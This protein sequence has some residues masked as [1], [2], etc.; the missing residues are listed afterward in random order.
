MAERGWKQ[1]VANRTWFQGKGKYPI[2]AYS[3]FMPPPRLGCK[4]Y[5]SAD[6]VVFSEEDPSGWHITEFEEAFELKPGLAQVAKQLVTAFHHLGRC[7]PSH[8]ISQYKLRDNPY[9]TERTIAPST[10]RFVN[11]SPLALSR[12]QDDK[13]RVRWTLFGA[14]EQGPAK[15]FW[16][17]FYTEPG[18]EWPSR[19]LAE[20]RAPAA[21]RGLWRKER[22]SG[23]FEDSRLSNPG[24][25]NQAAR[26]A[27]ESREAAH[28]DGAVHVAANAK[29]HRREIFANVRAVRDI[30]GR[31][32][33]GVSGRRSAPASLSRQPRLLGIDRLQQAS[34]QHCLGR[35]NSAVALDHSARSARRTSGPAV[36]LDARAARQGRRRRRTAS[37]NPQHLPTHASLEPGPSLRGR[38]DDVGRGRSGGACAVQH[39][40]RRFGFVRQAHGAQRPGLDARF[41]TLARRTTDPCARSD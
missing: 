27:L 32:S 16:Q 31:G 11:L 4:A 37:A 12:T 22:R 17:G 18:V 21:R 3:E 9:W 10:E 25:R 28:L 8:G 26:T 5:G 23:R 33:Q 30:A 19:A 39:A 38:A 13:G 15:G 34:P 20:F 35:A 1:L 36:G 2:S 24:R 29:T 7:E 40:G 6:G 41:S 14:S